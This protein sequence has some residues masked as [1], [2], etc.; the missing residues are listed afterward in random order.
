M[1]TLIY[2]CLFILMFS[3]YYYMNFKKLFKYGECRNYDE[4]FDLF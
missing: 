4:I 2:A 3:L 1:I